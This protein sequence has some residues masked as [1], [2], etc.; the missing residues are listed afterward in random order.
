M[1]RR[2]S[3]SVLFALNAALREAKPSTLDSANVALAKLYAA[4]L[5]NAAVISRSVAKALEK[6][7]KTEIDP[8]LHYELS[9]L[10]A[11]IEEVHVAGLLGPKLLAALEQLHLTP[12]ARAGVMQ[13]GGAP[14][15]ASKSELDELRSRRQNRTTTV[16]PAT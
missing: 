16:D 13:G 7:R 14:P 3:P 1:A 12:K 9:Q 2:K 5:D 10:A 8:E 11:R 15:S 6:L 4:E